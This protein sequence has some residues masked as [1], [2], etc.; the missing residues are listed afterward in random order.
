MYYLILSLEGGILM[1]Y[2]AEDVRWAF[3]IFMYLL[4]NGSISEDEREYHYAYQ[5]NEVRH[6]IEEI[7]NEE[8]EVMIFSLGGV[9]YLTPGIDN[10]FLGHSNAQLRDKMKLRTNSELYLAY[11]IILNLLAE[12]YNSEDQSLATRQFLLLQNL[13]EMVTEQINKIDDTD[14]QALERREEELQLN[15][16]A[17]AEV[18]LDLPPFDDEL[19]NIRRGR[20]NRISFILRVLSFLEDEGLIQVLENE[21][22]R[23]LPKLEHLIVKYYFNST[24]KDQLLQLI[25]KDMLIKED[26]D[27]AY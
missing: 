11:F 23:L 4:K 3:K 22:I 26:E 16:S 17:V 1:E 20:K 18:W 13:E 15:L 10:W 2:R 14:E 12:F 6:I 27:A 9:I 8:A 24:R 25:E 21:E 5:K 19:K 7:M